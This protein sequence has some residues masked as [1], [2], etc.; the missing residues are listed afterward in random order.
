[1]EVSSG[2]SS[3]TPLCLG[4]ECLSLI[5]TSGSYNDLITMYVS[6]LGGGSSKLALLL[7]LFLNLCNLLSLL[8]RSTDLHS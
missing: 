6:G 4:G 3:H 8:R 2:D 5:V 7:R 1:M